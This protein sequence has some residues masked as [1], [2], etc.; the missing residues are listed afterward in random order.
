MRLAR[1]KLAGFKSFVDPTLLPL[2][3]NRVGIVG[4]NGCGKSNT[5]D[6]VRWVMGES[7]AKHLRGDSSEDVIFNGSSSR[8]PVGQ[9]SIELFFDNS[10]GRLGGE[11]QSYAEI[12]V[13]RSLSR[14]G[15]SK[16]YLNG[17]RARK[18][19]VTD[20]FLGTG[21]GPRSYAIIEQGMI[22]R[23]IEAR[24]EELRVYLEE[25]AGISKYK[26]R[27]RETENRIR[28][29]R[30]NLERLE[31]VRDE[32]GRQAAKLTRQAEVAERYQT[33]AAERRQQRAELLILRLQALEHRLQRDS[34]ALAEAEAVL[35]QHHAQAQKTETAAEG[36]RHQR[37]DLEA[38]LQQVQ[39]RH[40]DAT[41]AVSRLEQSIQHAEA[42]LARETQEQAGLQ[43]RLRQAE[44]EQLTVAERL[45]TAAA[46]IAEQEMAAELA[47]SQWL[48]IETL[49]ETATAALDEAREARSQ[50]QQALAEPQQTAQLA[51][52]RMDH[53]DS[54][55]QRARQRQQRLGDEQAA[56]PAHDLA[57]ELE[58]AETA[59]TLAEEAQNRLLEEQQTVRESVRQHRQDVQ[60]GQAQRH[61]LERQVR[62]IAGQLAGLKILPGQDQDAER[63]AL[64]T[65]AQQ[66]GLDLQQRLVN[67]IEVEAGWERAAEVVLG[68]WFEA[69]PYAQ[70]TTLTTLP[71]AALRALDPQ[72]PTALAADP[73]HLAARIKAPAVLQS[74]LSKIRVADDLATA[75]AQLPDCNPDESIVTRTGT[76]LGPGWLCH[77]SADRSVEGVVERLRLQ[78][79]LETESA[80]LEAQIDAAEERAGDLQAMLQTHEARLLEL[81]ASLREG[82]RDSSRLEAQYQRLRERTTQQQERRQR[83]EQELA[84]VATDLEHATLERDQALEERNRALE[85]LE[86]LQQS[87]TGLEQRLHDAQAQHHQ[88]RQQA[89]TA[90]Q[91]S[92]TARMALQEARHQ[93]AMEQERHARLRQQCQQ[94]QERLEHLQHARSERLAPLDGWRLDLETHLEQRQRT[95]AELSAAR[96]ALAEC[97][98]QLRQL[99]STGRGAQL[100]VEQQRA[101]CE[102]R[103]LQQR[104]LRVQQEQLLHQFL[105]SGFE[106]ASL[107]TQLP[108]EASIE[109]WESQLLRLDQKIERLG[110]INLAAIDEAKALQERNQYLQ[111]QHDDLVTALQTLEQAMQKIDR[112]TRALF[113]ET[114]ERVNTGLGHKFRRLFGGGEA[115]LELTGEDLLD[116]GVAIMA[117]P[118]GKRLSTIHLMS[119]GEKALTAVALVFAIFEL[120]PAPFCM[121]DEVDAPLDE[122]NV[123]RFCALVE[124]MSERIQFIFITHN[125]TTMAMAQQLIGVTMHEPGVSRLV[126]VDIDT[127]IEMT[128]A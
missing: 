65:W 20:L 18:R 36:L 64:A 94:D 10:E 21:L 22:S 116:T 73:A 52:A 79:R 70:A 126:S 77:R 103:R 113:K 63:A 11:Y 45:Q 42:E 125:K 37:L 49:L 33:L 72:P 97:D 12:S 50:W 31:D 53:A 107:E 115:R 17:Q 120:N 2:P 95:E 108:T 15:Q 67:Y 8:K 109:D 85:T 5:I 75:Q 3:S 56:L 25:A 118:P 71:E 88:A 58:Q 105:D 14:D 87:A 93:H 30:E 123:G 27:R 19:D 6:A 39:D 112:E 91:R 1:I 128:A 60:D 99:A 117:R 89:Q 119:G 59:W 104:E 44:A 57:L 38:T 46:S 127:A 74:W 83:L 28:H 55:L 13:R 34:L 106:R 4:P 102:A 16:Y 81:E 101:D 40:Y 80:Q 100:A 84:E 68:H 114:Y 24:P 69:L 23:L 98:E 121:L 110:P 26:E 9:A 96:Q 66:Q 90:N 122:A 92:T 35:E 29:T 43:Q 51:R 62:E 78:R 61:A 111:E 76:W 54:L 32:V 48:E 124:E 7:S 82:Q 47:E 41:S 86:T